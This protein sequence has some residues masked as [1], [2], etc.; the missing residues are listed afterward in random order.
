[1]TQ[2]PLDTEL[3]KNQCREWLDQMK[4]IISSDEFQEK[5]KGKSEILMLIKS[6]VNTIEK[7]LQKNNF[8]ILS[9]KLFEFNQKYVEYFK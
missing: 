1:M 3:L 8:K 5:M 9:G 4:E 6:N 2:S 7:Q